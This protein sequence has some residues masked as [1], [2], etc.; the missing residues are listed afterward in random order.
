MSQTNFLLYGANGYTGKLIAK[1]AADYGLTPILAG[2]NKD[3]ISELATQ[4]NLPFRIV[5]LNDK[6]GLKK[7]VSEVKVVLHAAGPFKF[8]SKPMINACIETGTH[9]LDITGEIEVFEN[10]KR[11]SEKAKAKNIVL[12]PGVGFDVVP[13]DCMALHLKNQMPDATHLKLAFATIGGKISHGTA[14]TMIEGLGAGGAVRENGKIIRK[15]LGHKGMWV[16][17]TDKKLFVMAIPWG[18][19]STAYFTTGIPN[20]E[21]YTAIA[22][23]IYKLLKFQMLYNWVLRTSFIRNY[24]KRKLKGKPAG[25]SDEMR[26]NSKSYVWG[27]I[28]NAAGETI[29]SRIS[30][31]DGYTLTALS[32]LIITKKVLQ[33]D[34]KPGYQT[35]AACYGSTL[36]NEIPG[37]S[38]FENL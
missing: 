22:P 33:G 8:T 15:P 6:E 16:A 20:I 18:D 29:E 4:L 2:R 5:D 36:V 28:K 1:Y 31:P 24:F 17:F 37:T 9:Y 10:A 14:T 38:S 23:K 3:E 12:M 30:L 27:Q 11:S 32:S 35:P 26:L 25:P 7:I 19:L 21:T 34:F 13:T